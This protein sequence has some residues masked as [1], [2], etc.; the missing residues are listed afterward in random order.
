MI[1]IRNKIA[2]KN[3]LRNDKKLFPTRPFL[4]EFQ[5]DAMQEATKLI[6]DWSVCLSDG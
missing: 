4:Q 2:V 3:S 6:N 1:I 5:Q